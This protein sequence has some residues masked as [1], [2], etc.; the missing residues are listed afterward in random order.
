[1]KMDF[2]GG[3]PLTETPAGGVPDD[4]SAPPAGMLL[5]EWEGSSRER[6]GGHP[7]EQRAGKAG[8][9]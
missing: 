4:S 2:K 7:L 3:Q 8:E 5:R 1:M 9:A 6:A